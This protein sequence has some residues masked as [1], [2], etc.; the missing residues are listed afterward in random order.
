MSMDTDVLVVG[1]GPVG[2]ALAIELGMRG[3]RV[4]VAERNPRVG[5]APR[6]KTTNVRTR[7]HLRRWGLADRLASASP[8]GVDYPNNVIFS[9]GLS[10]HR[11]SVIE[12]AFNAAPSRSP[13]YPEHA[14]WL[15][16]YTLEQ[17]LR[18]HAQTLPGVEIRFGQTFVK[19]E[20]SDGCVRSVLRDRAGGESHLDSRYLVGADGARS[21]VREIIGAK[22][23][24]DPDISR[25]YNII[26]RAPGLAKAHKLGRGVMYWQFKR[27]GTSVVGPMDRDDIWVY[28][29]AGIKDADRLSSAEAAAV[30]TRATGIDLP[31][32]VLSADV[33]VASRLI[34]DRYRQQNIFLA[35]DACHLHPPFGGYG[36][37]MGIGDA[38]DLGWK[39][40]ANIAGW[41]GPGLLDSY[42]IERRPVHEAVIEEAVA[43]HATLSAQVWREG[44]DDD[45]PAGAA[46]RAEV[47]AQIQENKKREFYTLGTVLGLG[48]EG[49][50][51]IDYDGTPAPVRNGQVYTPSARPGQLAPHAWLEDGRSLYDLFGLAFTLVVDAAAN[52]SHVAQARELAATLGIPLTVASP[53]E[54]PI[55]SLYEASLALVRPDQM[56]AWRGEQLTEATFKRVAGGRARP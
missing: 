52:P 22:M 27:D 1:A 40:A 19:A 43:N 8:L 15:P 34:A 13:L 42:E 35:G 50:P 16:Q 28:V 41:G 36:M 7:T 24:G 21:A 26:F 39:I 23:Q 25:H 48:Y 55:R 5:V 20:Q 51:I 47:G 32:E 14:Q 38:V 2:L 49:S 3:V 33:W 30:I 12:D 44:L 31:Y 9:T 18:E 29:P 54:V 10:G 46:L 53:A 37:N 6:A 56:V 45:T 11:L 17:V 4:L